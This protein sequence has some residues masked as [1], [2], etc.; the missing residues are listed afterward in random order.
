[1]STKWMLGTLMA[2]LMAV[3]GCSDS[4]KGSE[5]PAGAKGA[6]TQAA[7]TTSGKTPP[8]R[9][10]R[11]NAGTDP[12]TLDPT[13]NSGIQEGWI[14]SGLMEG[15][16]RL[17][18][19]SKPI[20]AVAESWTHSEDYLTWT[21]TLRRDAK[22]HNG[23]P[24]TAHDFVYAIER[25]STPST[26]APYAQNVYMFLQGGAEYYAGGGK[27]KGLPAPG[28]RAVDD[29][30]IVYTLAQAAPYFL[31]VLQF[32]AWLPLHRPTIES[33]GPGWFLKP[34]T[35]VGNGPFRMEQYRPGDR[36][37][38]RKADTYWDRDRI[39]WD[40]VHVYLISSE[41]TENAAFLTGD[42]DATSGVAV[43]E[44]DKWRGKPEFRSVPTFGTQYVAFNTTVAP[45][46]DR[47]VRR[48]FS[49]AINRT[50]LTQQVTRRGEIVPRGIVPTSLASVV[51][52]QSY[53]DRAG[54]FVGRTDVEEARRLL[55]E[56]GFADPK[57][58]PQIEYLY[59]TREDN[60]LIAEQLQSMWNRAFGIDVRL[61][62][63]EWGVV[64]AALVS[65][66][67]MCARATWFGDYVDALAFL[68][69][70]E[71]GNS[72]NAPKFSN[73]EFDALVESARRET[74]PLK[75]ED[76]LIAA[77]RLLIQDEAVVAPIYHY[78]SPM[79]VRTDLIDFGANTLNNLVWIHSRRAQ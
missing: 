11:F 25:I 63:K 78:V 6:P 23:D 48:A 73:P 43:A 67:F 55:A 51:E 4:G 47:R 65:G 21:F 75:R 34:E 38:M 20:P 33:A 28:V 77:E 57:T 29:H 8:A 22:W 64:S 52:G 60:K 76:M 41:T 27:D 17:D 62:N 44:V 66:D 69:I 46:N 49:L 61:S 5:Q 1:M 79:L 12:S 15:L 31:T 50:L 42:L 45:F 2:G 16:I 71:T 58:L 3:V 7:T 35:F 9:T 19:D 18:R 68:E 53:R 32:T 10:L 54:N 14:L 56:A 40:D 70:F 30:T 74:D 39:W 24:V 59:N 26:A 36:I 72:K 13:F 37:V